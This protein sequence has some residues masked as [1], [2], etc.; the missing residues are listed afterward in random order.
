VRR[1]FYGYDATASVPTT[2]SNVRSL[3]NTGATFESSKSVW[4]Y[5]AGTVLRMTIPVGTNR[6]VV[7]V[8]S[9]LYSLGNTIT[10]IDET[11]LNADIT[12]SYTR[13]NVSV[14]GANGASAVTYNV[15][16]FIPAGPFT[17]IS[18]HKLTLN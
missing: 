6:V 15:Y 18:T 14:S 17:N 8:P 16:S 2:S 11:S 1:L 3:P 5:G 10:A 7:A 12:S 13:T 4:D 9:G